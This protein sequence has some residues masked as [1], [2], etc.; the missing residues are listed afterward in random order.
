M[1]LGRIFA[2]IVRRRVRLVAWLVAFLG[3]AVAG[4]LVFEIANTAPTDRWSVAG[5]VAGIGALVF[6][7]I[8]TVVAVV[9]YSDSTQRP[10]L[11]LTSVQPPRVNNRA[12][13]AAWRI[14]I[15]LANGGPVAARFVAVRI[16]FAGA[17]AWKHNPEWSQ[18]SSMRIMQWDGG[19]DTIIH[20]D[21][22]A[23][24]PSLVVELGLERT[25]DFTATVEVVADRAGT[26][27]RTLT[28]PID[29]ARQLP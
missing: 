4:I 5:G 10:A 21:W 23:R 9:A 6:A 14:D 3:L 20:P 16:T 1:G 25:A 27:S 22:N 17:L 15:T 12:E 13:R 2:E 8:A 28:V 7:F 29:V 26:I 19:V 11:S 18:G 24:I